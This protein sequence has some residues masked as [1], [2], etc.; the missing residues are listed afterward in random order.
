MKKIG[1]A[2][3]IIGLLLTVF[4]GFN[5]FTKK[6]IVDVGGLEITKSEPHRVK[7]TPYAGVGIM[8]MGGIILLVGSKRTN[9]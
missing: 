3:I 1:I 7:W 8:I 9:A 6:K 4:T 2:L 5:F